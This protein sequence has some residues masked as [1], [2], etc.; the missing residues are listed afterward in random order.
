MAR[1]SPGLWVL[2]GLL[3][4]LTLA[5]GFIDSTLWPMPS[6]SAA[7]ATHVSSPTSV[8]WPTAT[9]LA[10]D[11]GWQMLRPGME[12]RSLNVPTAV[13]T[14][15]ITV[16]RIDPA[17][18]RIR[19]LYQPG[20]G[21]PVSTWTQQTGALLVINGGYFTPDKFVTGL[22][23]S[24]GE[25]YGSVFG[26]YAGML[27][28][29]QDETVSVRW[30]RDWPYDPNEPLREAVQCFPVLVKPGGVMGFPADGDEGRISRRT[31]IGQDHE[32]RLL[33]LI[34]PRGYLSL[35]ELSSWLARS[36]LNLDTA[37][38]LDGGTSSGLWM[39]G[40]PQVDSM[41]PVPVVIAVL[42]P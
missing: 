22:T 36:D 17:E 4:S 34:A 28:V 2:G 10:P 39:P 35:H 19:V 1:K 23:I 6:P 18:F 38:N 24:S 12:V 20:G 32:G 11:T 8:P 29:G 27:A 41:I 14:E 7:P 16:V 15:R 25:R 9:P 3:L 33:L 30:L 21:Y 31:V 26:D 40:G 13:N 5:C 37:L 42:S